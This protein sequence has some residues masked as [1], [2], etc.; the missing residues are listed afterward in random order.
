M[1]S[2]LSFNSPANTK[3]FVGCL[4]GIMCA[5]W[6][7]PGDV[8]KKL[9]PQNSKKKKKK[10]SMARESRAEIGITVTNQGFSENA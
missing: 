1:P 6:S 2:L 3:A 8:L 5:Y 10:S 9:N 7:E 4:N